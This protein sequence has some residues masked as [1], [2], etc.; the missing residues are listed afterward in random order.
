MNILSKQTAFQ[1]K[2][3]TLS[4]LNDFIK[5]NESTL[6]IGYSQL[7]KKISY[8]EF[9]IHCFSRFIQH[10]QLYKDKSSAIGC[11]DTTIKFLG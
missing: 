1:F 10:T 11:I 4:E 2:M 9:T 6:L 3:E 8:T 7:T 5:T